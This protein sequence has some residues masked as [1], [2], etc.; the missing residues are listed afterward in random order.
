MGKKR[1]GITDK[2]RKSLILRISR[3]RRCYATSLLGSF[4]IV[5]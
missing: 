4:Y 3:Q 2:L 1:L 5:L